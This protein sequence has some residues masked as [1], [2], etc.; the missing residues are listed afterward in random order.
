MLKQTEKLFLELI[1]ESVSYH[2]GHVLP[3]QNNTHILKEQSVQ[4][5]FILLP[6]TNEK[7]LAV[8]FTENHR[9]VETFFLRC[10]FMFLWV[11]FYILCCHNALVMTWLYLVGKNTW[12]RL[13]EAHVMG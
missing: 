9:Y 4:T 2:Q 11:K 7:M 12:L 13:I 3:H 10:N 6:Q 8:S 5:H 1:F